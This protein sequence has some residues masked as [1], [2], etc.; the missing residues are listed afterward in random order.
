M[1]EDGFCSRPPSRWFLSVADVGLQEIRDA[2]H[3]HI[4]QKH[5]LGAYN[6]RRPQEL[7]HSSTI[8]SSRT[9]AAAPRTH[10]RGDRRPWS[11]HSVRTVLL[12]DEGSYQEC[13]EESPQGTRH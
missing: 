12:I 6:R 3:E 4:N 13:A 10:I 7:R 1:I 11:A 9:A 8:Q 2:R 5:E